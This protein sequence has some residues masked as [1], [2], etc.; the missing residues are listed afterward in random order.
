M[1]RA[2]V[3]AGAAWPD[4]TRPLRSAKTVSAD[5]GVDA[6]TARRYAAGGRLAATRLGPRLLR[7][8]P[9]LTPSTPTPEQAP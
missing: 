8:Q 9:D 5:L 2:G 7:F 4:T 3:V 6:S 1:E